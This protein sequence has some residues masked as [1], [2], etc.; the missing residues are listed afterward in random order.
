MF[1]FPYVLGYLCCLM[2]QLYKVFNNIVLLR[3][4]DEIQWRNMVLLADYSSI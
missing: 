1:Y 3:F 4:V 2:K